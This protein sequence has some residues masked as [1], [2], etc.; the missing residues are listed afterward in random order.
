MILIF[1]FKKILK[2]LRRKQIKGDW[3]ETI[4]NNATARAQTNYQ[5]TNTEDVSKDIDQLRQLS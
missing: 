3:K 1:L 4:R 5:N 2:K